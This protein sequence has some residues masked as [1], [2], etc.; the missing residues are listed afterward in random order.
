MSESYLESGPS[1]QAGDGA[2]PPGPL[3]ASLLRRRATD[4]VGQDTAALTRFE[5]EQLAQEFADIE[6]ASAA[7]RLGE[8]ALKSW[9]TPAPP[10]VIIKPRPLWLLIGILWL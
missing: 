6:R 4:K 2:V 9:T 3:S 8:P 5:Q 1:D 10:A 7:L